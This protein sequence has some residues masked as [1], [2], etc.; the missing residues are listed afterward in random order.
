MRTSGIL[1][2]F[3][4]S[5]LTAVG[6]RAQSMD[7]QPSHPP[8]STI[9]GNTGLWKVFSADNLPRHQA[10]FSV[11]YDRI[12]RNPGF[13]TI[14][15]VG[16]SG[17]AGI[18]DWLEF[19][20]NFEINK[21]I[22]AR[23]QDQLSFGQ[24][25]LGLFGNRTLGSPPTPLELVPG[26]EILPQLRS[27]ATRAGVFNGSAGYYNNLPWVGSRLQGNGVGT[28]TMGVKLNPLSEERG[29]RFGLAF[30]GYASI[31]THRSANFLLSRPTQTGDW[32]FGS[33]V[34]LSKYVR[35]IAEVDFNV[36]FRGIQSPAESRQM[37]LSD[38]VPIGFGIAIPRKTRIQVL[39]EVN[40][41]IFVGSHTPVTTI[42]AR[43]PVDGTIGF[44]A[45]L[46]KG[47]SLSGGYRHP[48]NQS[49]GD[50][51]G[52]I[53]DLTFSTPSQKKVPP[54][55][56]S[57]TCSADPTEI[58]AGQ[59]VNL[60][61]QGVSSAGKLL[62]YEWS[63]T[64]GTIDGSGPTVKLHT[65]NLA[66]G[67]YTATVR[68]IEAPGV[69][70]DC[71]TSV[72]V[73]T[74]PP[75]PQPPT[76][77]CSADKPRV[78]VGE[79]V[80]VTAQARS[81]QDRPLTY[82]WNS[83]GGRV[84]GTGAT[85][86]F[87]T[88]GLQPGSYTV[89]VRVTDDRNL[90]AECSVEVTVAA[91]PPPPPPPPPPQASK[92]NDCSFRLNLA[93]VDNVCKAKLD[94]VALRLRNQADATVTIVGFADTR[95]RNGARLSDTRAN[96]TKAYLVSEKGIADNRVQVR[97]GQAASG[98]ENR[99]VEIHLVPRG[100]SFNVGTEVTT[101]PAPARRTS[102]AAKRPPKKSAAIHTGTRGGQRASSAHPAPGVSH[103]QWQGNARRVIIASAR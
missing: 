60:S 92:L 26:S 100:A 42:D 34:I 98:P 65:D 71:T 15:T 19:G 13:L 73:R 64:G 61:A 17:A 39:A 72:T 91:P 50:K 69:S 47:L 62:T 77:T 10:S 38:E 81:P 66:P 94:D 4:I 22:L 53:A 33:D 20:M 46:T 101:P 7:D 32:I 16:I 76:V 51:N 68:A 56:P 86:R 6:A 21:H 36:G 87:D 74:P 35:D 99:K 90:S 43:D 44:R 96:N 23:R 48:F 57:L 2:L 12:N 55:P 88:T 97:R 78:Q 1:F 41:D 24:Q 80:T 25:A 54:S 63:T 70:A 28:V 75:P 58:N 85:V 49:G 3:I 29:D 18:T 95:E 9:Y 14:G 8:S 89:R 82:A 37:V 93:R 40:A 52:F 79:I 30:R 5:T 11:W 84:E 67:S 59:Q 83:T 27:P 103:T 45:W 31:P 102:G